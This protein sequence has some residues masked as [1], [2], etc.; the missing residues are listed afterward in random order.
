MESPAAGNAQ[1]M[2]KNQPKASNKIH[3]KI[4]MLSAQKEV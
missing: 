1:I 2:I 3:H 4:G